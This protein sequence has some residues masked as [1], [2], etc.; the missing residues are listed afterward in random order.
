MTKIQFA[1]LA[2]NCTSEKCWVL[3]GGKVYDVTRF[4]VEHPGGDD[5]ILSATGKDATD[6]F[7]DVGHSKTARDMLK[8][9]YIGEMDLSTVPKTRTYK[10]PNQPKYEQDQSA[11]FYVRALQFLLPI[12]ILGTAVAVHFYTKSS[13]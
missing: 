2:Q 3:I 11:Q 7:E 10:P 9:Y 8:D 4:L 12:L 1:E 5:V 6:D 13:A